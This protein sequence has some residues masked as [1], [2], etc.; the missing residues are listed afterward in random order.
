MHHLEEQMPHTLEWNALMEVPD[1]I[2][3]LCRTGL[4]TGSEAVRYQ[5]ERLR[6]ALAESDPRMASDLSRMLKRAAS[7]AD[8][9][10]SRLVRSAAAVAGEELGAALNPP[11]DK[12]TSMPLAQII[13]VDELPQ[14][15]PV[16]ADSLGTAIESLLTEWSHFDQLRRAGLRPTT[17]A[18]IYGPP[19]TGKTHLAL[20]ISAQL[21]LPVVL[22]RLDALVSSFLGTTSRNIAAL[23]S[24]AQRYRCVLLLDEFDS[25]A[26]MR[27]DPQEVGEIKRV[28]NTLLQ[29]LDGRNGAPTIAI[30]NHE[31]LLDPAVWRRFDLQIAI[32]KPSRR[33][34][35]AIIRRYAPP[36]VLN[37]TQEAILVWLLKGASGADIEV[38]LRSLKRASLVSDDFGHFEFFRSLRGYVHLNIA[39]F[40]RE[41]AQAL[42]GDPEDLAIALLESPDLSIER[43]ELA[44]LLGIHRNTLRRWEQKSGDSDGLRS[45]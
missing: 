3:T 12:E 14:Q 30:T 1:I 33:E 19:G 15:S 23:F 8:I 4:A 39:R 42:V 20:W 6:D 9:R 32:P 27:D 37:D 25:I 35:L 24:F 44:D 38:L 18:L 11:V 26:K 13:R 29:H 10:P 2:Q 34:R 21:G 40:Q 16:L 5:V 17:S 22:A 45:A 31:T 41:R 28:V 7:S 43:G 36:L